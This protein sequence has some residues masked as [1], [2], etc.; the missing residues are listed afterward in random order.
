MAKPQT[1]RLHTH[2]LRASNREEP[3]SQ[4][5]RRSRAEKKTEVTSLLVSSKIEN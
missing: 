2:T 5:L 1:L 4:T 3:D